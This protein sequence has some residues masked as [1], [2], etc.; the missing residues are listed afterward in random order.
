MLNLKR[1]STDI[2]K[3]L[4]C[5]LEFQ[6]D[7]GRDIVERGSTRPGAHAL[8]EHQRTLFR[9]LKNAFSAEI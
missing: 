7:C 5:A 2:A 6:S 9:H 4:Q 8:E 1:Q 3:L